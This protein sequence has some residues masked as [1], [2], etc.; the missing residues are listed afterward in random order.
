MKVLTLCWI[1]EAGVCFLK[2]VKASLLLLFTI[3]DPPFEPRGSSEL[4]SWHRWHSPYVFDLMTV[5]LGEFFLTP[6]SSRSS[7]SARTVSSSA[8]MSSSS[9]EKSESCPSLWLSG[10]A[11]LRALRKI[12]CILRGLNGRLFCLGEVPVLVLVTVTS[13]THAGATFLPRLVPLPMSACPPVRLSV[14]PS[15]CF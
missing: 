8:S 3:L 1:G 9:L 2:C 12:A 4:K 7:S 5:F 10:C 14:R 11:R 6:A 15:G 13:L